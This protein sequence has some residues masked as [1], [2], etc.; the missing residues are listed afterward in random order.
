MG[1]IFNNDGRPFKRVVS[2][3]LKREETNFEHKFAIYNYDD[4]NG[5]ENF[6]KALLE[7]EEC[8]NEKSAHAFALAASQMQT[9]G[10]VPVNFI[11]N[12]KKELKN[13]A[14]RKN[15]IIKDRD[16]LE[17]I[18]KFDPE[19]QIRSYWNDFKNYLKK[20]FRNIVNYFKSNVS[21]FVFLMSL[22]SSQ[23]RLI[24]GFKRSET[25]KTLI[26]LA[27]YKKLDLNEVKSMNKRVDAIP[28]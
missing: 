5:F 15:K 10:P 14:K 8:K 17:K 26:G 12:Y 9:N 1:I 3:P 7:T 28:E 21:D 4:P 13:Q 6:K 22:T 25:S 2:K 18:E 23:R 11:K 27:L 19:A 16:R 20:K 24:K